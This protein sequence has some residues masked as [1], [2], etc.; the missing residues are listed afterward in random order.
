MENLKKSIF[1]N[2]ETIMLKN[3]KIDTYL[4]IEK[5][6]L[7]DKEI[8]FINNIVKNISFALPRDTFSCKYGFLIYSFEHKDKNREVYISPDV[9]LIDGDCV[10]YEVL[11][12]KEYF[13]LTTNQILISKEGKYFCE[14][15]LK[16]FLEY[17]SLED[18]VNYI[19]KY[20]NRDFE[21]LIN[22]ENR[23]N[24]LDKFNIK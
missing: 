19:E 14:I 3:S 2:R 10:V 22:I 9:Y 23:L 7:Y 13:K 16:Q 15:P 17:V 20:L 5:D 8:S 4:K 24:F 12:H 21:E 18:I 6:S 11:N 1:D